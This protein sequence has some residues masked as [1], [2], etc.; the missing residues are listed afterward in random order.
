MIIIIT[1][2]KRM[3]RTF[4][5][6]VPRS[7]PTLSWNDHRRRWSWANKRVIKEKKKPLMPICPKIAVVGF[8]MIFFSPGSRNKLSYYHIFMK[9]W[10]SRRRRFILR[11]VIYW[12]FNVVNSVSCQHT[13]ANTIYIYHLENR[14]RSFVSLLIA[15]IKTKKM[16]LFLSN[17]LN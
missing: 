17:I 11:A 2:G 3:L 1:G 5:I 10:V 15:C 14:A 4:R 12:L 9:S 6:C 8:K 7:A 13:L 16:L